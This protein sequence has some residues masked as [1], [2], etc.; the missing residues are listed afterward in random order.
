MNNQK[1]LRT[2]FNKVSLVNSSIYLHVFNHYIQ[3]K[4]CVLDFGC[5]NG[6]FLKKIDCKEKFA[7]DINQL[8]F[9]NLKNKNIK[10]FD[11]LS[12]VN[13]KFDLI[14]ALS[15]IDHVLNPSEVIYQLKKKIKKNGKII[16]IVRAENMNASTK[17]FKYQEHLYSWTM[18][19]F[20]NLVKKIGLQVQKKF[21]LKY[22]LPPRFSFFLKILNK[23]SFLKL[24]KFFG[25]FY[26]KQKRLVF[27]LKK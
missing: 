1:K 8:H 13:K 11:T 25:L 7:V 17:N 5:N 14:F 26:S 19:S 6:D 16:I 15:V 2:F 20:E 12:K 3:K 4:F 27:I 24:C 18:L 23:N 22:V 10:C 9:K 21:Y